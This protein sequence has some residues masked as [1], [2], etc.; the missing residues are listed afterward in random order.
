[1]PLPSRIASVLRNLLRK[2]VVER[3][4]DEELHG[5]LATLEDRYAG[6]GIPREEARRMARLELGGVEQ[7]KENVRGERAGAA[8]DATLADARYAWRGL[9]KA[10]AFTIVVVLTLALGIGANSAIFSVVHAMLLAPLPYRDADRLIFVWSDMTDAGYPRA[11]LSGPE[12]ADLRSRSTTVASFGAIWAN[13]IA[14]TGENDPE[15]LR[16]GIVTDDFFNV[17]GAEPALGRTFR[18]EDAAAGARPT[19]LLSWAV[20]QRRFG[21]DATVVG[22]QILIN[23][24]PTTV[25]G[26][27]PAS[28][29]LLLPPDASV[30]DDLQAFTPF[31]SRMTTGPRGQQYLRVIGR[32]KP[33]V[34]LAAAQADINGIAALISREFTEYGAAGRLLN[35]VSLQQDDVREM[36]GALLALFAG[37]GILLT[38][39]CV[40]VASLLI[41]R[42]VARAKE[43][44]LRVALGASRSRLLRQ[45]LIEGLMLALL[46]VVAG[47]SLGF[48]L[49]RGL[50]L[51]RPEALSRIDLSRFNAPVLAF[52]IAVA[53]VWGL[54]CS[55][56][57]LLEILKTHA[58]PSLQREGRGAGAP[59]RSRARAALVIV[60][61][62]LSV[63]LLIGAALLVRTFLRVQQI[64]PGFR[65][66]RAL[67]FRIA[68]PFQRYRPPAGFNAFS[69]QLQDGLA[70][71]PGVTGAG[72]ISHLPYDSLPNWGGGYLPETAV[73]RTVAP[74]AD[75]RS[76]TPGLLESLGVRLIEG[77]TF[78][79]RDTDPK[80]PA[81]IVDDRLAHRMWPGRSAID[82]RLLLDPASNGTPDRLMTVIGVVSHLRLRSLVADLT[83]QVYFP[84]RLVLRNPMAYV[85]RANRDPGALAADVRKAIAALDPNLP[86][87]DVRTLDSYVEGARETRRFTMQLAVAFAL[88]ALALACVG[89]YGVIAYAVTRRRQEF[90]LRLALGAQ[91]WRVV[92]EVVREGLRL[93][94]TGSIAGVAAALATSRLLA[95]QLY[96]VRP[97]DPISYVATVATL[98]FAAGIACWIPARRATAVSPM[99]ALRTD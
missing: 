16:I 3:D 19:I 22:R 78:T 73:D 66:D 91:P 4:L 70:A 33:G 74:N 20:F 60:Q 15:Q 31:G 68:V 63:V 36:R 93:A 58:A 8:L 23:D 40:N 1:M 77:R 96:G 56:A 26:V 7:V 86:I 41:A 87:Y 83:E 69:K 44:A 28:F 64:D 43:T 88:V 50:Y 79:E 57:P 85:V 25:I 65:V 12:V 98:V 48:V 39:A 34:T 71:L 75:Y 62:G 42:A 72:A 21:A 92:M 67:T 59:V 51:L 9:M 38:I 53:V 11:P 10:P 61:L 13:T 2:S 76:V 14:L 55:L 80:N 6:K 95:S 32:M 47:I 37:V 99:E 24:R 54:L 46:G 29:R 45:C 90:G 94:A 81:V 97:Y 35:A 5:V 18:P 82:Q 84:E 52:I 49:L 89:V 27:M 17:L 30:P